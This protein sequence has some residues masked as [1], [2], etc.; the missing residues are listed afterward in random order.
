MSI[1]AI[2]ARL[3]QYIFQTNNYVDISTGHQNALIMD[4]IWLMCTI[5][6]Y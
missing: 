5:C 3:C 6:D 2:R 1:Y 4:N